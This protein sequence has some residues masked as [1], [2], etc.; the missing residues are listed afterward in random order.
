MVGGP[1][2]GY[3]ILMMTGQ[4]RD[5][6]LWPLPVCIDQKGSVL[7]DEMCKSTGAPIF[8]FFILE[9]IIQIHYVYSAAG[10]IFPGITNES[11][12]TNLTNIRLGVLGYD[13]QQI[14][15]LGVT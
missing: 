12:V 5:S 8:G 2:K 14:Q 7:T 6:P 3:K 13:A 9:C 1:K 4:Y 11:K 15:L 10:E